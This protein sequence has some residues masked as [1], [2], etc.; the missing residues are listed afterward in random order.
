MVGKWEERE[1][2]EERGVGDWEL[3][4]YSSLNNALSGVA[5]STQAGG[6]RFCAHCQALKLKL[7]GQALPDWQQACQASRSS[8]R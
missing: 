7:A 1:E 8:K 2:E 3:C 5:S 6:S 4:G